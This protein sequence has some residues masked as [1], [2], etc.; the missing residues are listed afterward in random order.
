MRRLGQFRR[1]LFGLS[2]AA[3]SCRSRGFRCQTKN[4]EVRFNAVGSAFVSGYH[5]ALEEGLSAALAKKLNALELERRGFAFEG[6][7]M[8]LTLL[9]CLTPWRCD[10]FRRFFNGAAEPHMY[11]AHVGVGWVWARWPFGFRR[12]QRQLD[13]LLQWLAFDGWGFHEGFFHWRQYSSGRVPPRRLT[14]Y[15]ERAF[16]QGLGRSW[17]FVDGGDPELIANSLE[18]FA[19]ERRADM[20]SGIGLAATYAGMLDVQGLRLLANMAGPY[21]PY[22]CQGATFAAK[23]RQ[24][25]GNSTPYT[26]LATRTLSGISAGEAAL[27]CDSTLENLP[28]NLPEP[29]YEIW[30]RRIQDYF[31]KVE[32]EAPNQLYL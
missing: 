26:D 8:A 5:A 31:A 3:T 7:A 25:A 16:Y 22:I 6:A 9:D 29:A 10:R 17:W 24:R 11:M 13:P 32:S 12:M 15:E 28:L 2:A 14:G 23:A 19:P 1:V 18:M 21:R 27:L 30:R 4:Q 20:W